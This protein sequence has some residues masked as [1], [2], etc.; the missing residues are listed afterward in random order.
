MPRKK[1]TTKEAV[2][3]TPSKVKS[4]SNYVANKIENKKSVKVKK[5]VS[6]S[7][8]KSEAISIKRRVAKV[9]SEAEGTKVTS[10]EISVILPKNTPIRLLEKKILLQN[11]FSENIIN[12]AYK[13]AYVSS[14]CLI[15]VGATLAT[16]QFLPLEFGNQSAEVVGS[17][18][19]GTVNMINTTIS[20]NPTLIGKTEFDFVTDVPDY[21]TEDLPVKFV[22][23]NA[24]KVIAKVVK[25]GEVGFFQASTEFISNSTYKALISASQLSIGYYEIRVYVK[26]LNGDSATSFAS[27]KFFVGNKE[28]EDFYKSMQNKEQEEDLENESEDSGSESSNISDE[29]ESDS[30]KDSN[31]ESIDSKDETSNVKNDADENE[32]LVKS[33]EKTVD[34][35]TKDQEFELVSPISVISNT[36]IFTT[37]N[38][39]NLDFLELYLR[40]SK[41]ITPRFV[42]LASKRFDNW[43]FVFD[44]KNIPNGEYEFFA[45]TKKDGENF[46][47]KSIKIKIYNQTSLTQIPIKTIA[48]NE[49]NSVIE[50]IPAEEREFSNI[51]EKEYI[52]NSDIVRADNSKTEAE[53]ILLSNTGEIS[54]LLRRYAIAVQAGDPSLIM[55]IEETINKKRTE[56]ARNVLSDENRRYI[57]D[58]IDEE[59]TIKIESLQEKVVAFE[60]L[61][62]EKSGG[63]TAIDSDDDGISDLDEEKLYKTN[64]K[65]PDTD[66]DGVLDG[67][68]IMRGFDPLDEKIESMIT[69]QSPKESAGLVRSDVLEVKEVLPVIKTEQNN[70]ELV[71]TE[72]RGKALPNSIV[73]IYIFST[74]IVVTVRTDAD[75]SF[76]YTFDKELEDG[77]HDVYVA[78]T[79]NTGDIIAQSNAFSFVKQAQAFTP[80][81]TSESPVV[82]IET[83]VDSA[84]S[85]YNTVVGLGILALGLILLMLGISLRKNSSEVIEENISV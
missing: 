62:K 84:K 1:D 14:I 59:M 76:V 21:V 33:E 82:A 4:V 55:S 36:A 9:I 63:S 70:T 83:P 12:S 58:D 26:P 71:S 78:V 49:A 42:T 37:K 48:E 10:E 24:D 17:T 15:L 60:S 30:S 85:T 19:P 2:K 67:I 20:S 43:Q 5:S 27:E 23:T 8:L 38:T 41:S 3:K 72:I 51:D 79:D 44:T 40:P 6:K 35:P 18:D 64:T 7:D 47:S 80:V 50:K 22:V 61:R 81:D 28:Q 68:E 16:L 57:A 75:G 45:K 53:K 54:E 65:E 32:N 69:F 25:V 13:I 73:N 77:K 39:K 34:I 31:I 66:G 52:P 29:E 56:L 74:P 46:V 11:L